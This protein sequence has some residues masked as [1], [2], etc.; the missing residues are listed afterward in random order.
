M[1]ERTNRPIGFEEAVEPPEENLRRRDLSVL[2][3]EFK[4]LAENSLPPT[5]SE[6]LFEALWNEV[7]SAAML[8]M[9]T[10]TMSGYVNL[11]RV[12]QKWYEK[13]FKR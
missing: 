1:N 4:Q 10:Q 9:N 11:L 6:P 12:M 13:E 2:Q 3:A 8:T 7:N 5:A